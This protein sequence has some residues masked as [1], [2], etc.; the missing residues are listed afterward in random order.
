MASSNMS[1]GVIVFWVR[2]VLFFSLMNKEDE[3][4]EDKN[5]Q[6]ISI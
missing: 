6:M 4:W 3:I 2:R 5:R 1:G